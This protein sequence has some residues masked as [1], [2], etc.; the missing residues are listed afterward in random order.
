MQDITPE[1]LEQ[2]YV[3]LRAGESLSGRG[4]S[5]R[6]IYNINLS[7]FLMFQDACEKGV[8]GTNPLLKVTRPKKDTK[9][10]R[11][12]SFEAYRKLLSD[13][14][15]TK[16]MECAVLLCAAL[17]LRRSE[18]IAVSWGDVDFEAGTIDVHSSCDDRGW[19]Q[20]DEDGGGQPDPHPCRRSS[21]NRCSSARRT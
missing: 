19:A 9:E 15:P 13:L 3:D 8:V 1:V 5:G 11:A 21:P 16:R 10:K 2:A 7:A 14:D 12:L 4:L 17:G 6:T 20:E 18:S